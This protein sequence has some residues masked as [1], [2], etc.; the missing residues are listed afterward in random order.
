MHLKLFLHVMQVG[1][2]QNYAQV[3]EW[4]KGLDTASN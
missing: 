2:I 4:G 1:K 3:E